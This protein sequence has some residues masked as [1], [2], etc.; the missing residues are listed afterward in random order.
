M[1]MKIAGFLRTT[2]LDWDGKV[3]C[4]VYLAGCN[5]RCPYCHNRDLVLHPEAVQG[6]DQE[7]VLG[8]IGEHSDFLDG[9]VI[10]GGEPTLD[11]GLLD[12]IK[13]IRGKGLS[14]KLDTN[15]SR[16]EVLDDLIG[17]GL[18]DMVAMDIKA[19]LNADRYSSVAGVPA[20]VEALRRS[21][22]I[23]MESGVDYEFRTTVAPILVKERDIEEICR[24]IRGA[25]CYCLHQFRPD[26]TLDD[27]LEVLDPYPESK[28]LGMAEAA[29]PY[30]R[31]VKVRGI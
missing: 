15:G 6:L 11:P 25:K 16:P 5:F 8:Y 24:E 3:A 23:I 13:R 27:K 10:S 31:R 21:I 28:V 14:I 29:R 12:L 26:V 1:A 18:V 19:P 9:A 7:A 2:L 4:T 22:R 17:A 20:D 30:V